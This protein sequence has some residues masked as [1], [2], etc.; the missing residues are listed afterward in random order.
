MRK[1]LDLFMNKPDTK[2]I[3]LTLTNQC[4]LNCVYCYEHNKEL[5]TMPVETALEIVEREMTA[6]DGS[7]FV[8]IYYFG[9]EPFLQFETI[10]QIHSYLKS[11]TW[12]KGWFGFSTTNG[13]LVH[14]EIQ[15]W[16]R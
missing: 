2:I 15:D 8:C 9:G 3:I 14:D 5:R 11:K 12:S 4:N 1:N 7:N 6:N 13:T 16:L 10:R